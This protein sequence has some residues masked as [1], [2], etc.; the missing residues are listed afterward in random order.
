MNKPVRSAGKKPILVIDDHPIY[1]LGLKLLLDRQPDLY[2][3][4][5]A[6]SAASAHVAMAATKPCAVVVDLRLGEEDGLEL[7]QSLKSQFPHLP[8][9]VVSQHDETIHAGRALRAGAGGYVMKE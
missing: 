2:C 9:L 4:G 1:R 3:C 8:I 7:V 5:E 6:G